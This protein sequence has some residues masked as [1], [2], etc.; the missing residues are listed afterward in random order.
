MRLDKP[1]GSLLL[2]WPTLAALWLA[3]AGT[4]PIDLIIVFTLG[5]FV[6][7]AAGCVVNDLADRRLDA[8]V[9]R[10]RNRPLA[11]GVLNRRQAL[12]LFAALSLIALSLLAWLNA[13]AR[14]LALG[15]FAAAV[16]YPFAKRWT[17]LPQLVLGVAFSWGILMAF[18]AVLGEVPLEG[19][20][21]SA[22]SLMW[23]VAYDTLYAMVDRADDLKA[24]IKSTAILFGDAD[25]LMV[26]LLQGGALFGFALVGSRY[27][28][29]A[30][31]VLGL[32]AIL[33]LF[34]HQQLL[35]RQRAPESC[36]RAFL[37]NSWVGLALF[38]AVVLETTA[39][40]A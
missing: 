28:F 24:G 20:L 38:A 27:G 23:I 18:A 29:G 33:G 14:W 10:T 19:W 36:F 30:A 34:I 1:I 39:A 3:A 26:G 16:L 7:R 21:L 8:L 32:G 22:A 9:A 25:R 4:P 35:I 2:L 40:P 12:A 5:V 31:F 13:A 11:K 15:G 6:M 17:Q 37:N